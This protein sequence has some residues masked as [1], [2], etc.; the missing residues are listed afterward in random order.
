MC[1]LPAAN[2]KKNPQKIATD[3]VERGCGGM[4]LVPIAAFI[5]AY[6]FF[7]HSHPLYSFTYSITIKLKQRRRAAGVDH[8]PLLHQQ[9]LQ[10][11]NVDILHCHSGGG[12]H[13]SSRTSGVRHDHPGR[14]HAHLKAKGN[15]C[16]ERN[17]THVNESKAR[18]QR[19]QTA[20]AP[21][22]PRWHPSDSTPYRTYTYCVLPHVAHRGCHRNKYVG[23]LGTLRQ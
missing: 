9:C 18:V 2:Q 12:G 10:V 5:L 4:V 15:N 19:L 22:A 16:T 20:W 13:S 3:R 8:L 17:G 14:F 21:L 1:L 23:Q 7:P 11:L 6:S